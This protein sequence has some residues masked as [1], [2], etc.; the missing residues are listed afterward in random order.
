MTK[1][2]FILLDIDGVLVR[3]GG[4][5]H[6]FINTVNYFLAFFGQSHLSVDEKIAEK[7]EFA[8]IQAEWDMVPLT[9]A[10]FFDWYAVFSQRTEPF[11]TVA[12]A[13]QLIPV[14]TAE[15]FIAFLNPKILEY[16]EIPLNDEIYPL[17]VL[18]HCRQEKIKSILSKI[19]A[20]P[21]LS[22]ILDNTQNVHAS[23]LFRRLENEILGSKI[24]YETFGFWPEADLSSSLEQFDVPLISDFYREKIGDM[25]GGAIH[26][27]M[28][29][30]RPNLLPTGVD[31]DTVVSHR[32][33]PEAE[34]AR[35][36][37]G[38]KTCRLSGLGRYVMLRKKSICQRM[39]I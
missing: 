27:C 38:W 26:A 33:L 35:K 37:I 15:D 19:W 32:I 13:A 2:V 28:M 22:E 8:G 18:N 21:I 4:Y 5:R 17:A 6:A 29:T 9:I 3:P 25:N 10:A 12:N 7:F 34:I 16:G 14:G 1:S 20:D 24:F 36:A 11:G 31:P 23:V 30:A 39:P